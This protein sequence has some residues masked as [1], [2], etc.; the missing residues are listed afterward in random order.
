MSKNNKIN[1]IESCGG[2]EVYKTKYSV[3]VISRDFDKDGYDC[4]AYKEHLIDSDH[5]SNALK[6]ARAQQKQ[7]W[8]TYKITQTH[9]VTPQQKANMF[10]A[11][12]LRKPM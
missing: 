5:P 8:P 9:V 12:M 3:H 2:L 6:L 10:E 4:S 11:E 1:I 7:D